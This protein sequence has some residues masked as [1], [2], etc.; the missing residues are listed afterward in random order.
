MSRLKDINA[1]L[2]LENCLFRS[3]VNK[4]SLCKYL[5]LSFKVKFIILK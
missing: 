5:K 2:S 4:K 3:F 1:C